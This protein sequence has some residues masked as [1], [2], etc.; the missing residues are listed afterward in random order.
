MTVKSWIRIR[1]KIKN[2]KT[3]W[4]LTIEAWK[5]CRSVVTDSH[6]LNEEQDPDPH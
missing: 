2:Q 1:I 3:W 5:V 6:H 4:T